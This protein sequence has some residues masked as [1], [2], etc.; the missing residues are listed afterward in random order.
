M[1]RLIPFFIIISFLLTSCQYSGKTEP[2][3]N[4]EKEPVKAVWVSCY[5]YT[6]AAGKSENDYRK[7]TDEMFTNIKNCGFNT[8]FV[9]LRAFG[10]SF[11]KSDIFPY[12]S[13]IA[14]EE[15]AE[16]PFDPFVI[17]LE[18][19]KKNSVSI[20]GWIN[21]FRISYNNNPE[22]LS[23]KNPAKIILDS[24]NADGD[25]C[26]LENGIFLNPAAT[27]AQKLVLDGI[28]EI[29]NK[30]SISGIH[31]DDYF[32][33]T[34]DPAIDEF[35]YS[36]YLSQGGKL[37]LNEW[38]TENVTAFTAGLYSAVKAV[39]PQLTVSISPCAIAETNKN[40]LYADCE[41]WLKQ[42]G[43]AD[44]I[45]PQIYFGFEHEKNDFIKLAKE[46]AEL[47]RHSEV[48]L[49]CGIAAYK[50]SLTDEYAGKGEKEWIT[51]NDILTR[52]LE[53]ISADQ[54]YSGFAVFSYSDLIREN[55]KQ[56]I[57]GIKILLKNGET[58]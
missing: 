3:K 26:I 19:A 57:D 29:I 49:M 47:P 21:P 53:Y 22:L 23:S 31:I 20:H 35:Q 6:C 39:N 24:G 17:L 56:E 18:S 10:D 12:S 15:G 37:P 50:C 7:I 5:D 46:W 13:Y 38:R 33:P 54:N 36:E 27:Y 32:Y 45:I 40:E 43:F 1:K 41:L 28:R 2:P 25:V 16:L 42:K 30:Y 51:K 52:Q 8:A 58:K 11:Y 55:C 4:S 14:G 34:A 44:I 48:K 9:H